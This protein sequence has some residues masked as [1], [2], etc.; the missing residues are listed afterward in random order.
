MD[1]NY[2]LVVVG[3][4]PGGYAAALYGAGAGLNVALVEKNKLGGTCLHVGCIPAK[5][6]LETAA[7]SRTVGHASEFGI[8]AKGAKVDMTVAQ[9]RKQKVVEQLHQ[10]VGKLLEGR[11]V[12]VVDGWGS[13]GAVGQV[14]VSGGASGDMQLSSSHTILA[15]GSVPRRLPGFEVDGDCIM[16]SDELLSLDKVPGRVAIIGGGAI[17]LEFASMLCD[18]GSQ[19][20]VLEVLDEVLG[21]VDADVTKALVRAFKKRKI[22]IRTGVSVNNCRRVENGL[23]LH[24]NGDPPLLV[25]VVVVC[26]GRVPFTEGL[27]LEDAGI[28]TDDG[29]YVVVDEYC[30]TTVPGVYAVGDVVRTPQLAHVAFAEAIMVIK[31]LL[32]EPVVPLDYDKVPWAI[33]CYPEVAYVGYSEAAAIAA[34]FEVT[35]S[36]HRYMGNGRAMILGETDGLVKVIAERAASGSAGRILGVHMVGPWVTEQLGQGYLA[37]NWEATATE[38]AELVQPHPTMSELFG[39]AALSLTGRALH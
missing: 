29:G 27:G 31:H 7:V 13:L 36:T 28:N 8:S 16:T 34:G 5:E 35:T 12:T 32:D 1:S 10:G 3:G 21:G 11:K 2:D 39:E 26:V 25:D 4:G 19:V 14:L 6:L 18:L 23:E 22:E 24:V 37:V 15:T 33:Y 20:V 17:G 9:A 38:V 30:Q